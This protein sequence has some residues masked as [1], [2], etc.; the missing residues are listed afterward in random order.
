[1][2]YPNKDTQSTHRFCGI[3]S[4]FPRVHFVA[5]LPPPSRAT[6]GPSRAP[7]LP[8]QPSLAQ[9]HAPGPLRPPP[10]SSHHQPDYRRETAPVIVQPVVQDYFYQT[11]SQRRRARNG[12]YITLSQTTFIRNVPPPTLAQV[13]NVSHPQ[14][15][16]PTR[17][18]PR[19]QPTSTSQA[20]ER[21]SIIANR[22]SKRPRSAAETT[23]HDSLASSHEDLSAAHRYFCRC[24]IGI[25]S[26]EALLYA[27]S[28]SSGQTAAHATARVR[29]RRG[30]REHR[31]A[32][33]I[34]SGL[35]EPGGQLGSQR[36]KCDM[37][38][39][40]KSSVE[41]KRQPALMG[42]YQSSVSPWLLIHTFCLGMFGTSPK[43]STPVSSDQVVSVASLDMFFRI[44]NGMY[45]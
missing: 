8:G 20:T 12:D 40:S 30:G 35:G 29:D 14:S 18:A 34:K 19:R 3:A 22:V 38:G 5:P 44:F 24:V 36:G 7:S 37:E 10:A 41:A 25:R 11:R 1:M 45:P 2:S 33:A 13:R 27:A 6:A 43:P 28:S 42:N 16:A 15:A 39:E 26:I 17:T 9:T 32:S 31:V 23:Y 4:S 21:R